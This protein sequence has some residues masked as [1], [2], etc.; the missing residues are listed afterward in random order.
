MGFGIKEAIAEYIKS[1]L[2]GDMAVHVDESPDVIA[3]GR[4]DG[5]IVAIIDPSSTLTADEIMIKAGIAPDAKPVSGRRPVRI[6]S[7][8]PTIFLSSIRKSNGRLH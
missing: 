5:K 4:R 1:G 2:S 6:L 3:V 8:M 7:R